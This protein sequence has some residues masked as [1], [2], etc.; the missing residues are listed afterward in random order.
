MKKC[1]Y[2]AEDIQDE[3]KKCKHCGEWLKE[4]AAATV[5]TVAEHA[6]V[7]ESEHGVVLIKRLP[8]PK[9]KLINLD[10]AIWIGW[11]LTAFF[12]ILKPKTPAF[13]LLSGA[14]LSSEDW[15]V[16][17]VELLR[18]F[19]I[20]QLIYHV[21]HPT[22]DIENW[23]PIGPWGYAWRGVIT[24]WSGAL[25]LFL[26]MALVPVTQSQG[27][28]LS[29]FL[30]TQIPFVIGAAIA[31]WLFFSVHRKAQLSWLLASFRGY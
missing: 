2:C 6:E 5:T 1:P 15:I 13:H 31:A 27:S 11:L 9:R 7:E 14:A 10:K 19:I 26:L 25:V 16:L 3:A 21:R 17:T 8:W 18:A 4:V 22:E 29:V 20:I 23:K 24:F 12:T 28:P 30:S